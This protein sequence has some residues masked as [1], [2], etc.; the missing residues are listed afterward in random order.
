MTDVTS[1]V[2]T[3]LYKQIVHFYF[4]QT[5]I[6]WLKIRIN[7]KIAK[8]ANTYLRINTKITYVGKFYFIDLID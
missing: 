3:L 5:D 7:I 4:W 6:R 1:D 8:E 2:W